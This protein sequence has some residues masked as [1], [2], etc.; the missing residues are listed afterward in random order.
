MDKQKEHIDELLRLGEQKGVHLVPLY[1]WV[2]PYRIHLQQTKHSQSRVREELQVLMTFMDAFEGQGLQGF[3]DRAVGEWTAE[4][5][6]TYL[7]IF[8]NENQAQSAQ[9]DI[10]KAFAH[11]IIH[12]QK[13]A[14]P[15]GE[16][17]LAT[18]WSNAFEE[19]DFDEPTPPGQAKAHTSGGSFGDLTKAHSEDWEQEDFETE[20]ED[21][22][23]EFGELVDQMASAIQKELQSFYEG[24]VDGHKRLKPGDPDYYKTACTVQKVGN[25]KL[26]YEE[27]D[28]EDFL[29][30]NLFTGKIDIF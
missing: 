25:K 8:S 16:P 22:E 14:F 12:H 1:R 23:L 19:D 11:Y 26:I 21:E 5:S 18:S 2:E 7:D 27:E 4:L 15:K 6:S 20:A 24:K 9:K 10:L 28:N 3:P 13:H 29:S 17:F 30:K